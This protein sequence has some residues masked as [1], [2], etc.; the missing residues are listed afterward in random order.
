MTQAGVGARRLAGLLLLGL[1]VACG[2]PVPPDKKAYVGEW[3]EKAMR[4]L[5]TQDGSVRYWRLKAGAN[6]SID[7]P[8]Q[9]FEGD[10][11]DV[12]VGPMS[13]RFI[14]DQ[15][16]MQVDGTWTMTVDGVKLTKTA[17]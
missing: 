17:D 4:L 10:H 1:L 6:V 2:K 15:P 8:L 16:P 12:G 9:G 14:V 5:I 3:R 11:F 7:G 13:T